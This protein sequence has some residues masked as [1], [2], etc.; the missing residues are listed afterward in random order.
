MHVDHL[1]GGHRRNFKARN[2]AADQLVGIDILQRHV[3]AQFK[4][5]GVARHQFGVA[6]AVVVLRADQAVLDRQRVERLAE[7]F[8]CAR[9][10]V[11]PRLRRRV[12]QRHCCDLD[13]FAGDGRAL[14]GRLRRVAKHHGDAVERDV[15]FFRH[16]LRQ[17]GADAGAEIDMAVV[18]EHLPVGVDGDVDFEPGSGVVVRRTADDRQRSGAGGFH[19]VGI[20][21]V[22]ASHRPR[23][24]SR[25]RVQHD[26]RPPSSPRRE[27]PHACRSGTGCSAAPA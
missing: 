20:G 2:R 24:P 4:A 15:E 9:Q 10:Q 27:S 1:A 18:S 16:D 6:D 21:G 3:V 12:T 25:D 14:I 8:G 13:G 5:H 11:M 26:D 7:L 17:R 22:S 23:L 19:L